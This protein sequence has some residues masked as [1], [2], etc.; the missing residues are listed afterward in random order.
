MADMTRLPRAAALHVGEF[1]VGAVAAYAAVG[2]V[3]AVAQSIWPVLPVAALLVAAAVGA[4][5]HW[6]QRATGLVAGL[7]AATFVACALF[8]VVSMVVYRLD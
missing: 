6:G 5:L 7:V 2:G 3:Y 4:E 8:A 1:A